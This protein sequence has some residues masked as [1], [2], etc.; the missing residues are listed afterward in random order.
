M[1]DIIEKNLTE[2]G[3]EDVGW[4]YLAQDMGICKFL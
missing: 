4:I 2:I 1:G 3:W